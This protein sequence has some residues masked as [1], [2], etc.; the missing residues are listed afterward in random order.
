MFTVVDVACLKWQGNSP[1]VTCIRPHARQSVLRH[2]AIGGVYYVLMKKP[3][4]MFRSGNKWPFQD[5]AIHS[6]S[7]LIFRCWCHRCNG[8]LLLVEVIVTPFFGRSVHTGCWRFM[9]VTVI[10]Q[11]VSFEQSWSLCHE[12]F[13]LLMV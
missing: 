13:L 9:Q 6:A 3:G 7:P 11:R 12:A 5:R 2:E 10:W 4:S 8:V 1:M